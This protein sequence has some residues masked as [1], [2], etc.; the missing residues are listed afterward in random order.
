MYV[1][2]CTSGSIRPKGAALRDLGGTRT[3]RWFIM[4]FGILLPGKEASFGTHKIRDERCANSHLAAGD[5]WWN[6]R[7]QDVEDSCRGSA[8][9]S[10]H[11]PCVDQVQGACWSWSAVANVDAGNSDVWPQK[12]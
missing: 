6:G 11:G 9:N 4:Y 2:C 7:D 10:R 12:L 3:D 5:R 8:A 1:G